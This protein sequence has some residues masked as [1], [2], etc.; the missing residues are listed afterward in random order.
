[1]KNLIVVFFTLF[2]SLAFVVN[3]YSNP[4]IKNIDL[5][6]VWD[7]NMGLILTLDESNMIT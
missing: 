2:F 4:D 3:A 1:M 7:I 5:K 6:T